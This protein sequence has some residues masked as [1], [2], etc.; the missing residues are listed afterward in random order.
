MAFIKESS[1]AKIREY[2]D[3][4]SVINDYVSLRKRG[5]NY[6]GLCPFHSEK[7]PSFNV[8][9]EKGFFYCFGC[10]ESGDLISFVQKV[11]NLSFAEAVRVIA[12]K[13]KIELEMEDSSADFNEQKKQQ[14]I[15]ARL[16]D[17]LTWF[18][19]Y[20]QSILAQSNHTQQYLLDRGIGK[21]SVTEFSI[22][23]CPTVQ[24]IIGAAQQKG[25]T[26]E[27]LLAAEVLHVNDERQLRCRFQNRL[28]FPILN[29]LGQTVGFSGRRL[30]DS[31]SAKYIN[32]PESSLFNKRFLL[33][34][35]HLARKG[36]K[37]HGN[38]V[39]TEG[40]FDVILAHQI[41]LNQVVGVMGTA[42]TTQHI[43]MIKRSTDK[44]FLAFDADHAGMEATEKAALALSE[45]GV[46]VRVLPLTQK[47]LADEIQA[48]H[49]DHI[50]SLFDSP[51]HIIEIKLKKLLETHDINHVDHRSHILNQLIPFLKSEKDTIVQNHYIALI[52][53]SLKIDIVII[54]EKL[55]RGSYNKYNSPRVGKRFLP[56]SQS[57]K[58]EKAED[59]LIALAATHQEIRGPLKAVLQEIQFS[60]PAK[61]SVLVDIL[62]SQDSCQVLLNGL[63]H[64]KR[65]LLSEI[66]IKGEGEGGNWQD[67]VNIIKEQQSEGRI[68][69]IQKQLSDPGLSS[70]DADNLLMELNQLVKQKQERDIL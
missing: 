59:Q 12:D 21:S 51:K 37:A 48:T 10:H 63:D 55:G 70:A 52:A 28:L 53:N 57:T 67:Y 65:T 64:S 60:D 8:N 68:Q 4:A 42:L 17:I 6:L 47:D 43:Q 40:Y 22:G 11:E 7:T 41:G 56:H 1:I 35:M 15:E 23:Q 20:T 13:L 29:H 3:I 30:D 50:Q 49:P 44:V 2:G 9:N 31:K 27:D 38:M 46:F 32:S 33:Y 62:Q 39:L 24:D 26:K 14:R 66:L 16:R 45:Q 36:C 54:V 25:Y 34:A 19:E 5:R 61:H 69:A 18:R 58:Y